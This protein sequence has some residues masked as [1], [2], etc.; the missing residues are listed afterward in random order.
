MALVGLRGSKVL[1]GAMESVQDSHHAEVLSEPRCHCCVC[2]VV[3]CVSLLC[4]CRCCV[5]VIVVCV[6]AVCVV[7]VCV[8]MLCVSLLRVCHCC[9]LRHFL[10]TLNIYKKYI[11]RLLVF[12]LLF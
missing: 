1:V 9:V 10:V 11:L 2:V 5:S 4:V 12:N 8:S 3:V 6:I 7:V